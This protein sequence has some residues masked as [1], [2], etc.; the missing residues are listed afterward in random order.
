LKPCGRVVVDT[1]YF[2]GL[3]EQD[4][5]QLRAR[6]FRV[7][8]SQSA[9][10]E[11]WAA[12]ARDKD[13]GIIIGPARNFSR[14][15][16]L[17]YPIAPTAGDLF[18][19]FRVVRR[20]R[21]GDRV[22]ARYSAWATLNWQLA[23]SGNIDETAL[24]RVG[25][26]ADEYL[27]KR[28]QSWQLYARPWKVRIDAKCSPDERAEL[29]AANA[30]AREQLEIFKALKHGKRH[31]LFVAFASQGLPERGLRARLVRSRF[32]AFYNVV[33]WHMWQKATGA[34][35]ATENDSEDITHLM[36]L[37]EPAFLLTRDGDLLKSV[38]ASGT[39]QAPWVRTL[40]QFLR[41][42]LPVGRPWG[43]SARLQAA[44]FDR[45]KVLSE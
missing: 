9:F 17:D 43:I 36:H 45:A 37:V 41:A 44:S 4:I 42:P 14:V 30:K 19:R 8:V 18:W 31:A 29:E 11:A 27:R 13:P 23:V 15:V 39:Y 16:D 21:D 26:E 34:Q 7:S 28:G 40:E 33:A 32:H 3:R 38:D 25:Q 10:Y 35:T 6:G 24:L 1:N 22:R 12:A 20:K 2:R 5:E